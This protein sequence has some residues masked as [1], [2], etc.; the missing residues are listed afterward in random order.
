MGYLGLTSG[1]VIKISDAQFQS[2]MKR[3]EALIGGIMFEIQDE[4]KRVLGK[5]NL[6]AIEFVAPEGS[7]SLAGHSSGPAATHECSVCGKAFSHA[8]S[9]SRH[10]RRSHKGT[11]GTV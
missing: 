10:K 7:S 4:E 8:S 6:N 11:E 5:V 9:L 3:R 1:R 2:F